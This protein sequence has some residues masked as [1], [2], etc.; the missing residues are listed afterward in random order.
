M[1]LIPVRAISKN[2]RYATDSPFRG[3]EIWSVRKPH[4]VNELRFHVAHNAE[5][6][7]SCQ[8]VLHVQLQ[9]V[10]AGLNEG[11]QE[12][13]YVGVGRDDGRKAGEYSPIFYRPAVWKLVRAWTKWFSDTPNTPSKDPD[14]ASIRILTHGVFE[15]VA[16]RSKIAVFNTHLDDQSSDA[17]LR[18]AKA[19]SQ[20]L[21]HTKQLPILL[22][23]DFNSEPH[24][25]AY[26]FLSKEASILDV[27]TQIHP[28]KRYGNSDT[29]TGFGFEDEAP[30]RIDYVFVRH[31]HH[32]PDVLS[33]QVSN[34]GVLPN[35]FDNGMFNSDHRAVVVDLVMKGNLS[36][37]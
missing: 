4:L 13:D 3:E 1:I 22:T 7:I 32:G 11:K 29:F 33:W 28:A 19:I 24:Q 2:I 21:H 9:D 31:A 8:E 15:H 17:R 12:W 23:G 10:L 36:N 26:Q 5:A 16:T 14:A 20:Y 18:A 35:K 30:K 27:C 37:H 25:E 34:Y 6:F